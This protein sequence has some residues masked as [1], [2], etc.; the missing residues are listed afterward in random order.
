[1]MSPWPLTTLAPPSLWTP[2]EEQKGICDRVAAWLSTQA[3]LQD[4]LEQRLGSR[5]TQSLTWDLVIPGH[6]AMIR[7]EELNEWKCTGWVSRLVFWPR[8]G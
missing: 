3:A 2:R 8:C 4:D 5:R 1:M 6:W 7:T